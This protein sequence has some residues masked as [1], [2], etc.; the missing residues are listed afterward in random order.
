MNIKPLHAS[1]IYTALAVVYPVVWFSVIFEAS[2]S[3]SSAEVQELIERSTSFIQETDTLLNGVKENSR[4][5]VS[6]R[7]TSWFPSCRK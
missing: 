4:L 2:K 1:L 3:L 5:I 7:P 6:V